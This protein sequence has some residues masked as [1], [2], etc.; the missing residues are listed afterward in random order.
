MV[1]TVG[2]KSENAPALD[3]QFDDSGSR[4]AFTLRRL[5]Y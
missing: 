4:A 3:S 2:G 5:A 1:K